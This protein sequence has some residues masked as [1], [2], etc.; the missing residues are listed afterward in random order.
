MTRSMPLCCAIV[1]ALALPAFAEESVSDRWDAEMEASQTLAGSGKLRE[2]LA[3]AQRAMAI[4]EEHFDEGDKRIIQSLL[5]VATFHI[6]L[7]DANQAERLSI[8]ADEIAQ[9]G[10]ENAVARKG[11]TLKYLGNVYMQQGKLDKADKA[12]RDA[13]EMCESVLGR[14]HAETAKHYGNLGAVFA[15]RGDDA[16]ARKHLETSLE[17]WDKLEP[18]PVY[19]VASLKNLAHIE[20]TSGNTAAA[21]RLY[22]KGVAIQKAS[23]GATSNKRAKLLSALAELLESAG[24]TDRAAQVRNDLTT[25]AAP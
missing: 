18:N 17:I 24:Q 9:R 4:A 15:K 2:G 22:E 25:L 14:D 6:M 1:C 3:A 21:I 12:F 11:T 23:Y 7:R 13:I 10:L 8:R 19:T 5:H 20:Q 16:E